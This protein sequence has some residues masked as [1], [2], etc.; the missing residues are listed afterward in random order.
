MRSEHEITAERD[1]LVQSLWGVADSTA[2]VTETLARIDQ[3]NWT[4]AGGA[5]PAIVAAPPVQTDSSTDL[6]GE[7][8]VEKVFTEPSPGIWASVRDT[9][10][11]VVGGAMASELSAVTPSVPV[12]AE[13][14]RH[15][16]PPR[17]SSSVRSS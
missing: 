2:D 10:G 4:L 15:A 11:R 17:R 13:S 8:A 12:P 9:V 3:L 6:P 14:V 7:L 5:A 16:G 1:R